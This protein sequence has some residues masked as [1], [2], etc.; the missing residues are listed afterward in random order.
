MDVP[1]LLSIASKAASL[2]STRTTNESAGRA[3]PSKSSWCSIYFMLHL[4]AYGRSRRPTDRRKVEASLGYPVRRT[5]DASPNSQTEVQKLE[6]QSSYV[7][8]SNLR[9]EVNG[10]PE[11]SILQAQYIRQHLVCEDFVTQVSA[12]NGWEAILR[13]AD[14]P[15]SAPGSDSWSR[16]LGPCLRIEAL[17]SGSRETNSM[18]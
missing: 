1:S 17:H 3:K 18:L 10:S 7:N 2:P 6:D 8:D 5:E 16:G 9:L 13:V 11:G 15:R 14:L 4:S 12:I